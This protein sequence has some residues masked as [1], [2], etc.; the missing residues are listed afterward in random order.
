MGEGEEE[1][2]EQGVVPVPMTKHQEQMLSRLEG[3]PEKVL[4]FA[5]KAAKA[6]VT[7]IQSKK[8]PVV[9]N[10]EQYLE[11]EDWQTVG[12]FY[13][14]T[15][16][17]EWTKPIKD[18]EGKKI[19]W[20][21]KATVLRGGELITAA[22]ASC[23]REEKNWANRDDFQ[24]RSMAQTRAAAK[25]LRNAF[26]WVVVLAGYKPTPAEEMEGIEREPVREPARTQPTNM[27]GQPVTGGDPATEKQRELIKKLCGQKSV[28]SIEK[29]FGIK[30]EDHTKM[31]KEQ[32]SRI[33]KSLLAYQPE[34][35]AN[36][37]GDP[38]AGWE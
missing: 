32:A 10:G 21:A 35:G 11:F 38:P 27:G 23:M 37:Y 8:K 3:D 19:G 18:D 31:T 9:I 4:E 1:V 2:K 34:G 13:G 17:T 33:I 12:R 25:A 14:A 7:I 24:L 16:G 29:Q 36:D 20:E 15:V 26:A 6:L 28:T 22:E 30:V 5:A